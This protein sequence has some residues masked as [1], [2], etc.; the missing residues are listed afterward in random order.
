MGNWGNM[1]PSVWPVSARGL[2]LGLRLVSTTPS[3]PPTPL[4]HPNALGLLSPG[5]PCNYSGPHESALGY[6][7]FFES[8]L[9]RKPVSPSLITLGYFELFSTK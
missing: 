9:L 1:V 2:V 8:F 3:Q 4:V 5:V 7:R 6:R